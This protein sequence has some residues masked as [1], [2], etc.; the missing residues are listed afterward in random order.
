[1]SRM[2]INSGIFG[3][4]ATAKLLLKRIA[5]ALDP[6]STDDEGRFHDDPVEGSHDFG[7]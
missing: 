4:V 1:M 6:E 7:V 2:E 5:V 3:S